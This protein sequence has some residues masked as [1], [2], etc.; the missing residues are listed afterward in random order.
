M[1]RKSVD[2]ALKPYIQQL[3]KIP[4]QD[5]ADKAGVSRAVTVSFRKK[6]GIPAYNGHRQRHSVEDNA[7]TA[8]VVP[9]IAPPLSTPEVSENEERSFKGRR[10]VLDVHAHLLG[11]LSD[12]EVARIAGVTPENV[13]TYRS[14][15]G[16]KAN[17]RAKDE[18]V[19]VALAV[20]VV[21]VVVSLEAPVQAP[22]QVPAP[23]AVPAEKVLYTVS[24]E[25]D[26][27]LQQYGILAN[28]LTEAA[29]KTLK[30]MAARRLK[31]EVRGIEHLAELLTF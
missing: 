16:I 24:I 3:G 18:A 31:G 14:R 11:T 4:D 22:V 26:G 20:A 7:A 2:S 10:S 1:A 30:A 19:A 27:Q 15:R 12:A 8:T 5:I 13:R 9:V 21:P 23:V 6:L 17:W 25:H 28:N 29:A